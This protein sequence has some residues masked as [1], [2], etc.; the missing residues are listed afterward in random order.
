M[1]VKWGFHTGTDYG[2]GVQYGVYECVSTAL[3]SKPFVIGMNYWNHL[4]QTQ[5]SLRRDSSGT[6]IPGGRREI[7]AVQKAFST[8]NK[9]FGMRVRI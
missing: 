5:S 3:T 1:L 8:G 6:I 9:T 4:G 7:N 2:D